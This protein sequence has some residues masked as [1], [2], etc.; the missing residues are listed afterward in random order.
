MKTYL[1][2]ATNGFNWG[3][4]SVGVMDEEWAWRSVVDND[5][6]TPLLARLGW[7]RSHI[8]VM[9]LQ[10]GEGALFRPG[11]SAHADLYRRQIWV[12]PLF[13]PFLEWLYQKDLNALDALRA[14]VVQLPEAAAALYGYRRS[15]PAGGAT[16]THGD[17]AKSAEDAAVVAGL[18]TELDRLLD[19]SSLGTAVAKATQALTPAWVYARLAAHLHARLGSAHAGNEHSSAMPETNTG[20]DQ[21]PLRPSDKP[22]MYQLWAPFTEEQVA[23]LNAY[24]KATNI[25][26][27]TCGNDSSHPVLIASTDGWYCSA[28]DYTQVWAHAAMADGRLAEASAE[29]IRQLPRKQEGD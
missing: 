16:P 9:D 10:T 22:N 27:F 4:F 12:C 19:Q 18:F 8:W 15:G 24:Q 5:T 26:P 1:F 11:G 29:A 13:E 7:A 2:E 17:T 14:K 21:E 6:N 23:G 20:I 28:C 3:K 25:H